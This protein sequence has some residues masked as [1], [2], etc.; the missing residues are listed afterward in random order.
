MRFVARPEPPGTFGQSRQERFHTAARGHCV[1]SGAWRQCAEYV[2]QANSLD[3]QQLCRDI[4]RAI[5][6][7][8]HANVPVVCLVGRFGG[9]GKSFLLAP[10]NIIFGVEH[11]QV[12]PQPGNFPLVG[13]ETKR[14]V[15]LDEWDFNR[16][17]VPLSTQLLWFE[18]KAFP[19]T[20]PQNKDY[21]GHVL[22]QGSAPIFV[23]CK[24]KVMAPIVQRAELASIQNQASEDTMLLRRLKLYWLSQKLPL[25]P[26]T[27]VRECPLCFARMVLHYS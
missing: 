2:M 21:H 15:V 1:C 5:V 8:R 9:E 26:G 10:L 25:E 13:L 24:E 11:V 3:P 12:T 20:R 16:Q 18:G 4:Y 14:C 27:V 6:D 23:T 19:I 17:V 22:Y 7:G